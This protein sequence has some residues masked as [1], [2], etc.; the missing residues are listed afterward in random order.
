M[1]APSAVTWMIATGVPVEATNIRTKNRPPETAGDPLLFATLAETGVRLGECLAL[2]HRDWHTGQGST[3]YLEV[4]PCDDHPHGM[5][6]KGGRFRRVYVSDDLERLYSEYLWRLVEA[7]A[8]EEVANLEDHWVFVNLS[9]GERFVA[10]RPESVYAKVRAIK[11]HL[12][13]AVP[14]EWTPHW[15]RHSHA[16]AL[17]LQGT[18]PHVVMRRLGHA[19][20][21]TTIGL[22]GWVSE[23]AELRAL[24]GWQNLCSSTSP[25]DA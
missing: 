13:P 12:G 9:R 15:F 25:A 24:A 17:L 19:D 20:I 14:G 21:Q 10:L 3:P 1:L 23:D 16:S 11:D 22:Y 4:V 6:A 8:A 2:R 18:P 7:G 5:R